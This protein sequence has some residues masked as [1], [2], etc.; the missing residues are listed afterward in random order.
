MDSR[1]LARW[2]TR[3]EIGLIVLFLAFNFVTGPGVPE[4]VA[5]RPALVAHVVVR[6]TSWTLYWFN[7]ALMVSAFVGFWAAL[8]VGRVAASRVP[9]DHPALTEP[10]LLLERY[11]N[12]WIGD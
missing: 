3:A 9:L 6:Q 11:I 12:G 10:T 2:A 7:E 8:I 5:G 1:S 4:V